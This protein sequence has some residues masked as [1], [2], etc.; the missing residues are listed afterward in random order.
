MCNLCAICKNKVKNNK[1]E[2]KSTSREWALNSGPYSCKTS[3]LPLSQQA[4]DEEVYAKGL[5]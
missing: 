4:S 1:R 3:A 5:L 2:K